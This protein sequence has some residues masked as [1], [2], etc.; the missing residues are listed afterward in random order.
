[1]VLPAQE[2]LT[3]ETVLPSERERLVRLCAHLSGNVDV[4]ED[5]AQETLFE[6]WRHREKLYDLQGHAQWLSSIARN[7][8]H[9]WM[10]SHGRE[11]AR[12]VS[13]NDNGAISAPSLEDRLVDEVDLELE[14]ERGELAHLLD[15]AMA[16]LPPETRA[17]LIERYI[18]ELPQAEVAARLGLTENL[19]AVRLHRGKLA[20][21]RVLSNELSQEMNSYGLCERSHD[22]WQKTAIWCPCCGQQ[23]LLGRLSLSPRELV[24][25]CPDCDSSPDA[26]LVHHTVYSLDYAGLADVQG[27]KRALSKVMTWA[28]GYYRSG[29]VDR[30]VT[31]MK[32]GRAAALQMGLPP[33]MPLSV[34][35][36]HGVHVT[37]VCQPSN[38]ST[39][40]GFALHLPEGRRFWQEHPRI[41]MLPEGEVEVDGRAAFLISFESVTENARFDVI[42]EQDTFEVIHVSPAQ[43]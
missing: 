14:L 6:A 5:L 42:F 18:N 7:V 41:H 31:C 20:L 35:K 26:S 29:L 27:Y 39:L 21:R 4:A 11:A 37:C 30:T 10:R 32:C 34:R 22:T 19:V 15:Q 33:D 43:L 8:C 40:D 16:L 3:L 25:R 17:I 23:R 36:R 1:M 13:F 9:R 28:N 24:L 2:T 38:F 12:L